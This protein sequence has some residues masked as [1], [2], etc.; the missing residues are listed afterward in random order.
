MMMETSLQRVERTRSVPRAPSSASANQPKGPHVHH[1]AD[2][3]RERAVE[4]DEHSCGKRCSDEPY[5]NDEV[6][7]GWPSMDARTPNQG[8][9]PAIRSSVS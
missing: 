6:S 9:G 7:D 3:N 5:A 1:D 2:G 4:L 8:G